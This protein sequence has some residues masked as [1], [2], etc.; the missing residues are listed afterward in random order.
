MSRGNRFL[1]HPGTFYTLGGGLYYEPGG[2]RTTPMHSSLLGPVSFTLKHDV[3]A[4]KGNRQLT[5]FTSKGK[6]QY[7]RTGPPFLSRLTDYFTATQP[8][9][10]QPPPANG[11]G[12]LPN[13]APPST[14]G[15]AGSDLT[16]LAAQQ[17]TQQPSNI[18]RWLIVSL[19]A[20][21]VW[22]FYF[23]HRG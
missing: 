4:T 5:G 2:T 12:P 9:A 10:I 11:A 22:H 13:T 8:T 3:L 19:V 23:R 20:F 14:G 17:G 16:G 15:T 18:Q 7:S 6:P 21:L 1:V